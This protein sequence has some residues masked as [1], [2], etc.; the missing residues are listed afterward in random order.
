MYLIKIQINIDM[1][2][3]KKKEAPSPSPSTRSSEKSALAV[4]GVFFQIYKEL[5]PGRLRRPYV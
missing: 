5:F 4:C 3:V 2:M 1:H